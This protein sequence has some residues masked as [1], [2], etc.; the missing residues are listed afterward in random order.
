MAKCRKAVQRSTM[1]AFLPFQNTHNLEHCSNLCVWAPV[2]TTAL[3]QSWMQHKL[4]GKDGWVVNI[5]L[6]SLFDHSRFFFALSIHLFIVSFSLP[7]CCFAPLSYHA[8]CYWSHCV[9]EPTDNGCHKR[10]LS[11]EGTEF[12]ASRLATPNLHAIFVC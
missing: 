11:I 4:Y 12:S 3:P 6:C 10:K 7:P 8:L 1:F 5:S 9:S 2:T